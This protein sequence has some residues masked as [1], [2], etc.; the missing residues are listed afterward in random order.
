M[1][2][3]TLPSGE[4][5]VLTGGADFQLKARVARPGFPSK[6]PAPLTAPVPPAPAYAEAVPP[7]LR[8]PAPSHTPSMMLSQAS[9]QHSPRPHCTVVASHCAP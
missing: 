5:V 9:T 8:L 2:Q 4:V 6:S 3:A 7:S 1:S